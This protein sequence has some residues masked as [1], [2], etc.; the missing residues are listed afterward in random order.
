MSWPIVSVGRAEE[1]PGLD[2]IARLRRIST[3]VCEDAELVAGRPTKAG[4]VREEDFAIVIE[5]C[6]SLIDG[7]VDALP[8]QQ[9]LG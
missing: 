1:G 3:V 9:R 4:A 6:R 2:P 8:V 5:R 7:S